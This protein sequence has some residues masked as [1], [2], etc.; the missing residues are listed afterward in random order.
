MNRILKWSV[1][2]LL[3]LIVLAIGITW[4]CINSIVR[5][6]VQ[7]QATS[8]LGVQTT[9]AGATVSLLG[10]SV[11]LSDLQIASPKGYSA[12]HIFTVGGTDVSVSLSQL[13]S[14]PMHVATLNVNKPTLVIE[15]Q[16]MK[17]NFKALIDGM[18]TP[19]K[20]ADKTA[21]QKE[22]IKL[23]IDHL[24]VND[25]SI[26]IH[27]GEMPGV[28]LPSK[29]S[30]TV[31]KL[32]LQNI[33]NADGAQNG[34]AIKEI[35]TQ[36]ITVLAAKASESDQLPKELRGLMALDVNAISA[37]LDQEF[38]KQLDK[39]ASEV[40]K[41]LPKELRGALDTSRL[42][43]QPAKAVEDGLRGILD[44]QSRKKKD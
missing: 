20:Q 40:T 5:R 33:G 13:R 18:P 15:Q 44:K 10:G 41:K 43:T 32:D 3:A 7:A 12:P 36:L 39:V 30:L 28:K 23:I 25:A 9:L 34:A 4:L 8:Q 24:T 22:P 17:L 14:T 31:P 11:G 26:V 27:P 38:N 2:G 16:N 1:I 21:E 19:P 6:A 37:Q 42:T 29:I 35:F